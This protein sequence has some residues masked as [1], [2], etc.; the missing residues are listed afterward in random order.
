M[1][2]AMKTGTERPLHIVMVSRDIGLFSGTAHTNTETQRRHL[3]YLELLRERL[4]SVELRVIVVGKSHKPAQENLCASGLILYGLNG[5]KIFQGLKLLALLYRLQSSARVAKLLLVTQV[6]YQEGVLTLAFAKLFGLRCVGQ[7]HEDIFHSS[8]HERQQLSNFFSGLIL[9]LFSG[10][11][12]V[13]KYLEEN[14][15]Q[16]AP[17]LLVRSIPVAMELNEGELSSQ[18]CASKVDR[19]LFVGRFS[20]VK[21]LEFWI[22]IAT[23]LKKLLPTTEFEWVGS[24]PLESKLF[25]QITA[26]GLQNSF[27]LSGFLTGEE[28]KHAYQRASVFLLT[29]HSEGFGRVLVESLSYAVPVIA[30]RLPS[31]EFVIKDGVTGL[32]YDATDARVTAGFVAGLCEKLIT[33]PQL[34]V[35]MGERSRADVLNRFSKQ[36]L[37][38]QWVDFLLE[39]AG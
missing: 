3:R 25:Q 9:P 24:G 22:N 10:V 37:S 4:P 33:D 27:T 23:E 11:R 26:A 18:A 35:Q 32:L 7:V 31:T 21:N 19:V 2:R 30:P 6:V 28:L 5:H 16:R 20:P 36:T 39:S 29:S 13:S 17:K 15:R 12:V 38:R 14:I 34:R 1:E 8:S